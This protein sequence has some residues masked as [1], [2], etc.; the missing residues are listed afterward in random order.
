MLSVHILL[1]VPYCMRYLKAIG[2][3]FVVA[4]T[5]VLSMLK[6][7]ARLSLLVCATYL[8]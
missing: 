8:L 4:S 1:Q 6:C 3:V 7:I 5:V 2:Y